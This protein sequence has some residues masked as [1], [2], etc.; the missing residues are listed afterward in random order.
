VT[1]FLPF[2]AKFAGGIDSGDITESKEGGDERGAAAGRDCRVLA[3][4]MCACHVC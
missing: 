2:T 1:L 4:A 3:L